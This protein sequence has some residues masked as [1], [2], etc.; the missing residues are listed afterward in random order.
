MPILWSDFSSVQYTKSKINCETFLYTKS[1]TIFKK[2]HNFRFVFISKKQYTLH[3]G[4][5]HEIFEVGIYI[6]KSWHFALRDVFIYKKLDNL[7]YVFI[8][9]I[10]HFCVTRYFIEFLKFAEGGD[11]NALKKIL[12]VKFLYWKTIYFALLFCIHRAWHFALHF[13]NQKTVHFSLSLYISN[14]Y[15]SSNI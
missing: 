13:N 7:R 3:Y 8:S 14:L 5:F 6:Q 15:L 9:K 1:Q 12:C 11:I 2:L 4:I 10:R